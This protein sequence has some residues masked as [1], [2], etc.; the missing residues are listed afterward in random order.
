MALPSFLGFLGFGLYDTAVG[1]V[2][3]VWEV[4]VIDALS[5]A[6]P[7][8]LELT[9]EQTQRLV[10]IIE[11]KQ[12]CICNVSNSMRTVWITSDDGENELRVSF[13]CNFALVIS[14]VRFSIKRHGTMSLLL[15]ALKEICEDYGV[16]RIVMQSVLTREM[17]VFCHKAGF[18]ADPNATMEVDGILTGDYKLDF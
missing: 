11:D 1:I 7:G 9:K 12:G 10:N 5:N 17:E 14:R 15:D 18:R 2:D 16:H 6:L 4:T 3:I 8:M 13:L